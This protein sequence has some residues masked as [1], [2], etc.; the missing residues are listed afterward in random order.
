[1]AQP[2]NGV[3]LEKINNLH[4]KVDGKINSLHEKVDSIKEELNP[5]KAE[6]RM[7]TEF[8]VG[9]KSVV[10]TVSFFSAAF[11]G[12]LMWLINKLWGK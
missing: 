9:F 10:S 4:E 5:L 12:I 3:L 2:S 11:G 8:R 1:M 6:V 7:N